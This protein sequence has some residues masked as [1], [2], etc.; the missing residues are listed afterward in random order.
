MLYTDFIH[1]T[2]NYR[3]LQLLTISRDF[4]WWSKEYLHL[5]WLSAFAVYWRNCWDSILRDNIWQVLLK[6]QWCK[7]YG[8][9]LSNNFWMEVDKN[10]QELGSIGSA[11]L[12]IHVNADFH[13][14]FVWV[15]IEGRVSWFVL[16]KLLNCCVGLVCSDFQ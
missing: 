4:W 15:I 11:A 9:C 7:C 2:S 13:Y 5:F 12:G 6:F 14:Y 1:A 16:S 8:G 10:D 3:L